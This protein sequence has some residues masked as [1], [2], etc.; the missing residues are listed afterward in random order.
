MF[1]KKHKTVLLL[2]SKHHDNEADLE[3]GKLIIILEY[4]QIKDAAD[5][6]DQMCHKYSV[7][8]GTKR[9]SLSAFYGMI[10]VAAMNTPIV[11]NA[12]KPNWNKNKIYKRYLFL[13]KLEKSITGHLLY[14]RSNISKFLHKHI[15][16]VLPLSIILSWGNTRK[17]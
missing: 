17:N 11:S 12:K 3:D 6:V 2:S 16:N 10:D 4:N 14:Y 7:R 15:Q 1:Q 13:E 8:R 5:I 9:W